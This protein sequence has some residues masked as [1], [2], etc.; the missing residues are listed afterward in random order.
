MPPP[1]PA[2]PADRPII[3]FYGQLIPLHGLSAI[4]E[5]ARLTQADPFHW[6][7]VGRGQ[8]EPALRKAL[9]ARGLGNGTWT[10]WVDYDELPAPIDPG[11]WVAF[12]W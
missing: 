7:I 9:E 12:A 10:P 6:L 2:L 5:A 3:L 1:A 11:F 4:L 8:E